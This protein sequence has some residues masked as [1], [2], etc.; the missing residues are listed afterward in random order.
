MSRRSGAAAQLRNG[1]PAPSYAGSDAAGVVVA[2]P[3]GEANLAFVRL[4]VTEAQ[5]GRS[6]GLD[7]LLVL[8]ALCQE[9]SLATEDAAH[10]MQKP[11]SQARAALHRLV[12]M[13]LVEARGATKG[14]S[15]HLSA[16]AY[17]ALGEKA[18]YVRQRG[19]EP[20]QQEQMALQFVEKHGRI[21][22]REAAELCQISGSQAYRLLARLAERGLLARD[23]PRGRGAGYRKA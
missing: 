16:A 21:T 6:L 22:R 7:H 9:R 3:G 23:E 1:R 20:I 12:E 18:A 11:E 8:N 10:L 19:M 2:I 14:R 5:G 13:G 17:R 15:W 4:L